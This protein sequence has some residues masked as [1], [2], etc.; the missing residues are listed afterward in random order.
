[1]LGVYTELLTGQEQRQIPFSTHIACTIEM[2]PLDKDYDVAVIDEIQMIADE[3]R[4]CSWSRALN[5]L[6]A[7]EVHICGGLEAAKIVKTLVAENGDDFELFTYSRLTP[8]KYNTLL[9]SF[10]LPK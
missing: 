2:I 4:G 9:L 8:L 5:G 6:R 10:R 1:M 3:F 7:R